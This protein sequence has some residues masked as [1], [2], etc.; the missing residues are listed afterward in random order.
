M[1]GEQEVMF[2]KKKK[3]NIEQTL[4][5]KIARNIFLPLQH[6]A[7]RS[8]TGNRLLFTVPNV[9]MLPLCFIMIKYIMQRDYK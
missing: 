7:Q 8:G 4:T 3:K 5:S 2:S 9:L 6:R 1:K